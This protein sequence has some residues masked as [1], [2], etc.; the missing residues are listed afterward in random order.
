MGV[1]D[2]LKKIGL[3]KTGS[4]SW[5]GNVQDQKASDVLGDYYSDDKKEESEEN[6]EEKMEEKRNENS[7][8]M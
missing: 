1:V 2:F 3:L 8:R 7:G 6:V 5:S 4:G